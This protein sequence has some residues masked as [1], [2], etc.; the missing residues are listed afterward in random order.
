MV[1]TDLIEIEYREQLRKGARRVVA[2]GQ[3]VLIECSRRAVVA[4]QTVHSANP[5][6]RYLYPMK[7]ISIFAGRCNAANVPS[8]TALVLV[9]GGSHAADC[10]DPTVA[11]LSRL[12]PGVRVLAVNLPGRG[13]EP[14]DLSRLTIADCVA[15]VVSQ[16]DRAG[17]DRVVLVGHSMAGITVPGVAEALGVERLSRLVFLSCAIPPE[18]KAIVDTISGALGGFARL[19]ARMGGVAKPMP[20]ALAKRAFCNGMT[21]EQISFTLARQYPDSPTVTVERVH[22]KLPE[23]PRTWILLEQDKALSP[24]RQRGFIENLGG[25]DEVVSLDT[26]HDA[27]ISAPTELA[28]ILLR[29]VDSSSR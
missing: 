20:G 16:I 27:M 23:V 26:C 22:R 21:A 19:R 10:W 25:V 8:T 6:E 17:L 4:R 3:T 1:L 29:Y 14:G 18:G 2:G 7:D 15:S 9:H 13:G 12:A 5:F 28:E 11:E 24:K